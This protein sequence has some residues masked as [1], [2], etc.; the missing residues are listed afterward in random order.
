MSGRAFIDTNIIVYAFDRSAP[1]K[2]QTAKRII[3][4]GVATSQTIIS[5]Q[6][7]QEFTN[8]ALKGF[9]IALDSSDLE[10]FLITALFPMA[11]VPTSPSLIISALRLQRGHQL[12]WFDSMIVAA[13]LQGECRVLYTED[14]QH[15]QKFGNLVVEN[16]FLA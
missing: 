4:N 8:V 12:S 2:A 15:G 7:V 5:Y 16:P 3:T 9:R 10:S 14:L 13:A 1:Q 6:V 11:A